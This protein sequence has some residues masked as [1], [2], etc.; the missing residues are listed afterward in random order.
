[1]RLLVV[2]DNSVLLNKIK[3][4]LFNNY[5]IDFAHDSEDCLFQINICSYQIII[6][7]LDINDNQGFK[8][9]KKL[10]LRKVSCPILT[11]GKCSKEYTILQIFN[12]SDDV[13][14][15][16]INW[17]EFKARLNL[18]LTQSFHKTKNP[19]KINGFTLH[20]K[21]HHISYKQKP[22]ELKRKQRFILEC[23]LINFP[24]IVTK[25]ILK[26]YVWKYDWISR[27]NIDAHISQ[28]RKALHTQL[29]INPIKT[30]YGV[31]YRLVKIND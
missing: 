22:L 3:E 10:T 18:L 25:E 26:S 28:L 19:K 13:L 27:N 5:I 6:L 31:G 15:K 20:L 4:Q 2:E 8:L 17:Q 16:P 29:Q 14:L 12:Y 1:M 21:N 7:D 9:L 30:I 23:L 11:L 24:T